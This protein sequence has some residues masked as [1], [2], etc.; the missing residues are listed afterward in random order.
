MIFL[1]TVDV[2]MAFK[3]KIR[4]IKTV[5]KHQ[6]EGEWEAVILKRYF[7]VCVPQ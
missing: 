4:K 3:I 1:L 6:Y 7:N 2:N 5:L